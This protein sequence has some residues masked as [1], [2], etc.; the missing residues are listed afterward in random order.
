MRFCGLD[1]HDFSDG[2]VLHHGS[3]AVVAVALRSVHLALADDLAV[4]RLQ[5]EVRL[6]ILGNQFFE[7]LVLDSVLLDGLYTVEAGG[8]RGVTFAGEDDLAV[9][10]L[11]IELELAVLSHTDFKFCHS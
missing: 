4:G 5:A 2:S 3:D 8:L 11:E 10:S 7:T 6:A 1:L 9:G